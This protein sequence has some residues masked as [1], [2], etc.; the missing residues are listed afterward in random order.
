[1]LTTKFNNNAFCSEEWGSF[2]A[3]KGKY[4]IMKRNDCFIFSHAIIEHNKYGEVCIS[5]IV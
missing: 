2:T 3:E 5:K 4:K 1:V